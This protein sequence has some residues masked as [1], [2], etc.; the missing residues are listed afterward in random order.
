MAAVDIIITLA[1]VI[2]IIDI[3]VCRHK[4]KTRYIKRNTTPSN[5]APAAILIMIILIGIAATNQKETSAPVQQIS[6]TVQTPPVNHPAG[7][8]MQPLLN[9]TTGIMNRMSEGMIENAKRVQEETK[10]KIATQSMKI[11][12]IPST[13][14][15]IQEQSPEIQQ[16]NQPECFEKSTGKKVSCGDDYLREKAAFSTSNR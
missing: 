5:I 3:F 9:V 14:E 16:K 11:A 4:K 12:S 10:Q 8:Y 13:P 2:K 7:I 6:A 1:I 15:Q